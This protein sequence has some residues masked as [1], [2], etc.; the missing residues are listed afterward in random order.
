MTLKMSQAAAITSTMVTRMDT[1][2]VVPPPGRPRPHEGHR[3]AFLATGVL[4]DLQG[5]R[6]S[7]IEAPWAH[8]VRFQSSH[9][10]HCP[11]SGMSTNGRTPL[12][13]AL[14]FM[15]CPALRPQRQS[16]V[17]LSGT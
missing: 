5:T 8:R 13:V 15:G 10:S 6:V 16:L 14:T 1:P 9:R 2:V 7:N 3:A 17:Q 4:Q 12:L 11:V